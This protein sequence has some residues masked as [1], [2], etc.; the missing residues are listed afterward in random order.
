MRCMTDLTTSVEP[1]ILMSVCGQSMVVSKSVTTLLEPT[2]A[3]VEM[4]LCCLKMGT[5]AIPIPRHLSCCCLY[6]Y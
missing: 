4:V 3:N 1:L 5:H 2:T 6:R